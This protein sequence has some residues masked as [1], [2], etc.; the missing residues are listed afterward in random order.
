MKRLPHA[1][2]FFRA[3]VL[4]GERETGYSETDSRQKRDLLD[5][6][7]D[8]VG[9]HRVLPEP[10]DKGR[11]DEDSDTDGRQIETGR[12]RLSDDFPEDADVRHEVTKGHPRDEVDLCHPPVEVD[13]PDKL[14]ENGRK[15]NTAETERGQAE[16]AVEEPGIQDDVEEKSRDKEIPVGPGIPGRLQERIEDTEEHKEHRPVE[17]HV[18]VLE[19]E[20]ECPLIGSQPA[21]QGRRKSQA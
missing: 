18:H 14:D 2:K 13:G 1:V 21:E 12:Q 20:R 6:C 7:R 15:G 17:D 9:R 4:T 8:T 11:D 16:S 3:V 5:T 10:S 19:R